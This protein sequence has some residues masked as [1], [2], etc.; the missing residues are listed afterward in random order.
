[1]IG[2][3]LDQRAVWVACTW[4]GCT[5]LVRKGVGPCAVHRWH[6]AQELDRLWGLS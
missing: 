2:R 1:M 4:T 6:R 5:T 3:L